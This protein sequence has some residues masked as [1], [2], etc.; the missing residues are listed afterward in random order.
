M[1]P[2]AAV[3]LRVVVSLHASPHV[4]AHL[5]AILVVVRHAAVVDYSVVCVTV[6]IV[7][8]HLRA[9]NLL[10]VASLRANPLVVVS[11][12]A[13]PLVVV[14]RPA[15]PTLAVI[16]AA[17]LGDVAVVACSR[18]FIVGA[19]QV[20]AAIPAVGRHVSLLVVASPPADATEQKLSRHAKRLKTDVDIRK[21]LALAKGFF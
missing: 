20:A 3:N 17:L 14:S 5:L 10:V 2:A 7:A 1:V 6:C 21:P 19:G 15:R 4:V 12:H 9:A 11:Q 16:A 8:V 13:N 18:V